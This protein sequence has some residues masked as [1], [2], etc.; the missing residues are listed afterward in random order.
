M[1]LF[2]LAVKR[3]IPPIRGHSSSISILRTPHKLCLPYNATNR[4]FHPANVRKTALA[5]VRKPILPATKDPKAIIP[6]LSSIP[7]DTTEAYNELLQQL[8]ES[9]RSLQAQTTYDIKFRHDTLKPNV[10]TYTQLMLAYIN[11]AKYEEAMDIYYQIR[12]SIQLTFSVEAYQQFIHSLTHNRQNS[13]QRQPES[14]PGWVEFTVE[15]VSIYAELNGDSDPA[16]LTAFA[17]FQDMRQFSHLPTTS[18]MY[19]DLLQAC[20]EQKDAYILERLHK[21]LRMDLCLDPDIHV[22]HQLMEAYRATNDGSSVI[23]IWEMTDSRLWNGTTASILLKTC[24]ENGYYIRSD[25]VWERLKAE[26]PDITIAVDDFN[27]YL[28]CLLKHQDI[29]KAQ[30]VLERGLLAGEADE[31]SVEILRRFNLKSSTENS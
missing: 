5:G 2:K 19:I 18:Q 31:S 1:L 7:E 27:S 15:D 24:L 16:L 14:D 10:N 4:Y 21:L 28:L 29:D 3:A 30:Q 12:D 20:A 25:A 22:Y 23:E 13:R 6:F 8:A 9:G 17:L 26:R 11:D